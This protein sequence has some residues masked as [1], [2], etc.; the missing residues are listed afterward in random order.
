[1]KDDQEIKLNEIRNFVHQNKLKRTFNKLNKITDKWGF[2]RQIYLEVMPDIMAKFKLG[3]RQGINPYFIDWLPFLSPIEEIAWNSIRTQGVPLYPQFPLFN[4]FIDFANPGLRIGLE[5]DGKD[6]HD[7]QKDRERDYYLSEYG[8]KIFRVKGTETN[9]PYRLPEE[10]DESDDKD[11][12]IDNWLMNTSDGV[13]ASLDKVYFLQHPIEY[14]NVA[15]KS[16][17]KHRLADFDLL[18]GEIFS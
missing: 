16:L 10:L 15:L 13:I 17:D 5:I 7:E 18:E 2:L 6:F 14:Y 11:A 4:Y 12:E 3:K 8:W 9:A 1:M